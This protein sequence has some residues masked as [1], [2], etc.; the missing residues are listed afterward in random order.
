MP[1]TWIGE[2]NKSALSAARVESPWLSSS[3]DTLGH[4]NDTTHGGP[5]KGPG[6]THGVVEGWNVV[7][8]D[9]IR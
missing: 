2:P 5:Q 1:P 6:I 4:S 3:N 7:V 8:F 9:T